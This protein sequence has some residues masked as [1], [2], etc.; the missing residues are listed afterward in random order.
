MDV[1]ARIAELARFTTD[2][3]QYDRDFC[4]ARVR[5]M[6]RIRRLEERCA[7]LYGEGKIRG[8]LH[9][10]I[11]EEA[12]AAG[13]MPNLRP[14]DNVVA[15][16]REHGQALARGVSM[17][18]IMA[19]M[20]GKVEG[21]S[22]GRGGSMHLFDAGTRFYGGNAIV[23]GGLPLAAGLAL[24]DRMLPRKDCITACFFGEGAVAEGA[25]HE[26]LNLAALWQ[27]P[28]LFICENNLYAMGT[29]L[30]RSESQIDL[31]KKAASY[32]LPTAHINGMNVLAVH[33]A[34]REAVGHVRATQG[35]YFLELHTYRFRAHSM[36]DAELY[37][38]KAEVERW[39]EHGPIHTFT[40]RLKAA[41]MMSEEDFQRLDREAVEEVDAAVAFAES[42]TWEPVEELARDV[43]T[44]AAAEGEAR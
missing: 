7:E 42:G 10:Y 29:A 25:F 6:L 35:P 15:T 24:A 21:C 3:A 43:T 32:G 34:A 40:D 37:R 16:Y 20:F 12:V 1:P 28:V 33:D 44:P 36:F 30:A 41:G 22:R 11:G 5:D 31:T 27:L 4:L 2:V 14:E 19:E 9:L 26:S 38:D 23:G 18:A 8:F 13:V 17:N 39:K